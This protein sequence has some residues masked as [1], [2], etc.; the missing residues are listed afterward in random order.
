MSYIY[1]RE[2]Y[3]VSDGSLFYVNDQSEYEKNYLLADPGLRVCFLWNE[4]GWMYVYVV[5][6]L[7]TDPF[8]SSIYHTTRNSGGVPEYETDCN[9]NYTDYKGRRVLYG[10]NY[11]YSPLPT[12]APGLEVHPWSGTDAERVELAM[13][14]LFR[15]F[16]DKPSFL[17]GLAVGRALWRPPE[18]LT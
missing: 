7:G 16:Y 14:I 1:H 18:V 11:W 4:G 5:K 2:G 12:P 6:D 17:A 8:N 10:Y 9:L 13:H 15:Y 3:Y